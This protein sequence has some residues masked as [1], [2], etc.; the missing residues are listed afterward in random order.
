MRIGHDA[1]ECAVTMTEI[2]MIEKHR[3][4]KCEESILKM[5]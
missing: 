1:P 4:K 2:R 5:T 3:E